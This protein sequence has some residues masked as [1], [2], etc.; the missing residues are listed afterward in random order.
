MR[1]A[2]PTYSGEYR[3]VSLSLDNDTR[4][5][6]ENEDVEFIH[7]TPDKVVMY[8]E[9][10]ILT[11]EPDIIEK[12]KN[13]NNYD[14]F[15]IWENGKVVRCYNNSSLENVFF[16]TGRC[17]SNCIMC[18]SS[19]YSRQMSMDTK[20]DDLIKIASH[21]PSDA[22]HITITGG[23]PFMTGK[24]LFRLLEYCKDKFESTEFQILTNGRI[25]AVHDYCEIL[26]DTIPCHTILGIPLHGS[27]A[28]VHDRI[29]RSDGSF[30]QTIL[31]LRRLQKMGINTEIRI[32][33]CKENADDLNNIAKLIKAEFGKVNYVSIMAMEMTGNAYTNSEL[34]WIPYRESFSNVRP[35]INT[36]LKNGIDV[37][38]YN[39]PLCTVDAEYR[40]LCNKSISSW[41]VRYADTCERCIIKNSCGGVF[42]GTIRLEENEL[43]AVL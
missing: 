42:A 18:P 5:D 32:V 21:I 24:E 9:E 16:V 43:E 27:T 25:F 12:F 30:K 22:P 11:E 41:K 13:G 40:T 35:A 31:G 3:V 37:R 23:E 34:V 17:N 15:E 2:V 14:V 6:L 39:F 7:V 29:T 10:L 8:P 33:V 4:Q 26:S 38:L 20:I 36:L 28:E 19:D 1:F